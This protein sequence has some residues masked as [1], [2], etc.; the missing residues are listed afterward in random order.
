[1][2]LCGRVT[3]LSATPPGNELAIRELRRSDRD[4]FLESIAGGYGPFETMIGLARD[5]GQEFGPVFRPGVWF[6][7]RLLRAFGR[8]PVRAFVLADGGTVVATTL[9]IPWPRSGYILG[10]GVRPSYRRRGLANRLVAHAEEVARRSHRSWA[11][12]DVEEDNLPAVTLYQTR[13]Y[14]TLQRTAWWRNDAPGAV[15]GVAHSAVTLRTL[16]EKPSRE[17][18]GSWV[19]QHVAAAITTPLP[20]TGSR[21]SHLE[22]LGQI[23]GA[24]REVWQVGPPEAPRG[25]LTGCWRGS[26]K[27]GMLFLP[28]LAA[29]ILRDEIVALVQAGAAWLVQRGCTGI[30]IAAADTWESAPPV[31]AELGFVPVLTTL[32]MARPLEGESSPPPATP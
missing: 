14:V 22:S 3:A 6:V 17:A 4:S 11:V 12:L 10:V 31:F 16:S 9:L 21:L 25:V 8:A 24:V 13:R 32:T 26:G 27:P 18:A 28:A 23:P 5:G 30:L 15:A 1:V 20:P 29:G 7:L 19:A 2:L